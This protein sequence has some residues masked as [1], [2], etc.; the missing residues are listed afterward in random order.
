MTYFHW[1]RDRFASPWST[2][3]LTEESEYHIWWEGGLKDQLSAHYYVVW[4]L[5]I[6]L[7]K[8][9]HVTMSKWV[10]KVFSFAYTEIMGRIEKE[11]L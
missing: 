1:K 10:G 6:P 4:L 2:Y 3:T 9:E 11:E 7:V 8:A 5:L